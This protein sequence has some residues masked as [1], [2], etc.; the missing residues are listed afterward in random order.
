[1]YSLKPNTIEVFRFKLFEGSTQNKTK[2]DSKKT[3]QEI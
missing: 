1:M 3:K 2:E